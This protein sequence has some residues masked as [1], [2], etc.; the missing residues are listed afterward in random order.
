MGDRWNR[1]IISH[2]EAVRKD[3]CHLITLDR[4]AAVKDKQPRL[5]R[6]QWETKSCGAPNKTSLTLQQVDS[7]GCALF[8]FLMLGLLSWIHESRSTAEDGTASDFCRILFKGRTDECGGREEDP[9][10]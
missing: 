4:C 8:P 6:S 1:G 10:L 9:R 5:K 7:G 3:T 2:I